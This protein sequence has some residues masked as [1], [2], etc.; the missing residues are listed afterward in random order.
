MSKNDL[1]RKLLWIELVG[2]NKDSG[3]LG[4]G[5][6]LREI[7]FTPEW[8]SLLIT[9]PDFV[10]LHRDGGD[11]EPMPWD[12]CAYGGRS[13]DDDPEPWT[14]GELKGLIK[15]FHNRGVKV[16][17]A[18]MDMFLENR[19]H[20]EWASNHKETLAINR[21]EERTSSI[22]PLRHL[23]NG[24]P[25]EDFFNPKL[26]EVMTE[27]DFD[28]YHCADG[29]NHLRL[30]LYWSDYSDDMV[31]QFAESAN[32]ALP[33]GFSKKLDDFPDGIAGRAE[34][35]WENKRLEWI[36]FYVDRW[37][38]HIAKLADSLHSNEK[39]MLFNTSW[40]RDPVEA[41]WRYGIDY[42]KMAEAGVDIFIV[43]C[44]G[45]TNEIA[46]E[47]KVYPDFVH[48]IASTIML[49][50][51]CI[52]DSEIISLH[53]VHDVNENWEI[54]RHAPTALE[55]D[56]YL[57]P[58][59]FH[60]STSGALERCVDGFM[61]CLANGITEE[62]WSWMRSNWERSFA[63]VP[64]D[65]SSAT[66]VY[67]Y[68]TL[69]SELDDYAENGNP[70]T[71]WILYHLLAVGAPI[72]SIVD[73][74]N[75]KRV[76]GPIVILNSHH[77]PLERLNNIIERLDAPVV[78][79]GKDNSRNFSKQPA[80]VEKSDSLFSIKVFNA[81]GEFSAENGGKVAVIEDD[82]E[83]WKTIE[84]P[85]IYCEDLPVREISPNFL[86]Q[87]AQI[88]SHLSSNVK[89]VNDV[90]VRILSMKLEENRTRLFVSNDVFAYAYPRIDVGRDIAKIA[91][92]T[93][94]PYK[95]IHFEDSTLNL[96]VPGKGVVVID[97]CFS[98]ENGG[99]LKD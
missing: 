16:C 13:T 58:N 12:Y 26:K 3:D 2:F 14:K 99:I 76:N 24:T 57:Y 72:H 95:K 93:N 9:S 47:G 82:S 87:C 42:R 70:T 80:L 69:K 22:N 30:P 36:S 88:I 49:T 63:S 89:V 7:G 29:R 68:E 39:I 90:P 91:T 71:H 53:H 83:Q 35:I 38:A 17:F 85:K 77:F 19:F 94:F 64:Q 10:H 41:A 67:S 46:G 55:K 18:I 33:D 27:Y 20:E 56:A 1:C 98:V 60:H 59:L 74:E 8:I 45:A 5:T 21:E 78:L 44:P 96:V 15:E 34:W 92:V 28:G 31:A 32:L 75:T 43:E 61:V 48:K 86:D 66:L 37:G 73:I 11:D 4:V 40:T 79:L 25:Y 97:L 51:A 52:P 65:I 6:Y 50:K 23:K 54:L 81:E 84:E 62:E